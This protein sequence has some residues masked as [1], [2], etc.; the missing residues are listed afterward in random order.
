MSEYATEDDC[1]R[2]GMPSEFIES[3]LD[4]GEKL[5]PGPFKAERRAHFIGATCAFGWF[6]AEIDRIQTFSR[7]EGAM[8]F[9][10]TLER[11][12]LKAEVERLKAD[13]RLHNTII[14]Q[15]QRAQAAMLKQKDDEI[16]SLKQESWRTNE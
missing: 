13:A 7:E 8:L 6:R 11:D 16:A 14:T 3:T 12:E 1:R 9:D 15:L 4:N 2:M 5:F 10:M